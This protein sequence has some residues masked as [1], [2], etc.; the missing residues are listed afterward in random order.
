MKFGQ[1]ELLYRIAVGGMAE[2]YRG[3][4]VG[5]EGFVKQVAIKR[6]LPAYARDTRFVSMLLTE[7]RIHAQLSH[8]NI[9]QIQDL[10][11][12][13]EGEYF[14]VLEFVDG[15][16]LAAVLNALRA[17]EGSPA[18][19]ARLPDAVA[20]HVA[21]EL[22]E[23]LHFA[24]ELRGTDGEPLG[25]V[26]RDIS[27]GNVLV[28]YAGEVKLSD[29]GL[30]KR[31]TDQSVLGSLKGKLAYM[32]PEQARRVA[33]D[34]R[35]DIF[36]LGAV[37]FEMLTGQRL[38][39]I[40]DEASGWQQ[41]ASGIVPAPR[42]VRPDLPVA[43]ER[44]LTTTLAPD[45]RDR[46]PNAAAFVTAA[47][48]ALDL[49]PRSRRGEVVDLAELV[50]R[51]L[52]PGSP[53]P[54]S[55]PS[56]VIRLRSEVMPGG[57]LATAALT[58]VALQGPA[59]TPPSATTSVTAVK[60][61]PLLA[62]ARRPSAGTLPTAPPPADRARAPSGRFG[63]APPP[64]DRA[65]SPSGRFAVTPPLPE[66]GRSP[67]GRFSATGPAADHTHAPSGHF[68]TAPRP[69]AGVVAESKSGAAAGTRW[70]TPATALP[71]HPPRLTPSVPLAVARPRLTP[72]TPLTLPGP[73]TTGS[74]P[75]A[76]QRLTPSAP[77]PRPSGSRPAPVGLDA[78]GGRTEAPTRPL[79][80]R[81]KP[82]AL[83]ITLLVPF[84]LI[85]AATVIHFAVTPLP[86]LVA[87]QRPIPISV[88]SRP[89]G[90]EVH[91][92]GER[93]TG[94]TPISVDRPRDRLVHA[95]EVRHGD[96]RS[97]RRL[98]RFDETLSLDLT[99]TLGPPSRPAVTP[100]PGARPTD[101]H[102]ADPA[103][104]PAR[105]KASSQRD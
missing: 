9:V 85:A 74:I 53:R 18:R 79:G 36:A 61:N 52:P 84:T 87:W 78:N 69:A 88:N 33:L 20:L 89:P 83:R 40:A 37:L 96:L 1:Y 15:R 29:F 68:P 66:R 41:V 13:E 98:V 45:P 65:R 30:A 91:L 70:P 62:E 34:R 56:K 22:G 23:G 73:R 104:T 60:P 27:P 54:P 38:R 95:L 90:A 77:L 47:R 103:D 11:V 35:S 86:V 12:S 71:A 21:I 2:V 42:S 92:D 59:S 72:A 28:S 7:A 46:F 16:D 76:P 31:Q 101:T 24:H 39:E 3:R 10:G 80:P 97:V 67:S 50:Q 81:R 99:V 32:S 49:L 58:R 48:A 100:L 57:G 17:P 25:L 55:E 6:V 44:L 82:R 8:R 93:L 94:V 102:D 63:V 14:I 64:P 43:L 5:E 19:P 26:H 51:A 4:A 105:A 75:A